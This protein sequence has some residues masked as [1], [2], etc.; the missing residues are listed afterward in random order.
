LIRHQGSIQSGCFKCFIR[1]VCA[2]MHPGVHSRL[3]CLTQVR[4][5][6]QNLDEYGVVQSVTNE[7]VQAS[8]C[9]EDDSSAAGN[10]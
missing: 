4:H 2:A 9:R 6:A 7:T 3:P 10:E 8:P 1:Q 5:L